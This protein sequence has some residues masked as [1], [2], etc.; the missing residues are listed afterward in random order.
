MFCSLP[1]GQ[2]GGE[3]KLEGVDFLGCTKKVSQGGS[4]VFGVPPLAGGVCRTLARCFNG[5]FNVHWRF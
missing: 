4:S 3:Q 2:L 5:I 1:G